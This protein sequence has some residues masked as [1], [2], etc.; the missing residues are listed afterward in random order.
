MSKKKKKIK[1]S[2]KKIKFYRK[3]TRKPKIALKMSHKDLNMLWEHEETQKQ[4]NKKKMKKNENENC[5]LIIQLG[6]LAHQIFSHLYH[7]SGIEFCVDHGLKIVHSK[8]I[9]TCK[10]NIENRSESTY[11]CMSRISKLFQY[12]IKDINFV[13]VR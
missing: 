13:F 4:E 12:R 9:R 1:G 3:I 2:T 11:A 5:K 10:F 7:R 6:V 8:G